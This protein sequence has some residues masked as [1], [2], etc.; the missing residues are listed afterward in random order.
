M[1]NIVDSSFLRGVES[2]LNSLFGIDGDKKDDVKD[3]NKEAS[4]INAIE[5]SSTTKLVM[6]SEPEPE[7]PVKNIEETDQST[8][9]SEIEKRFNAIFGDESKDSKA[10]VKTNEQPAVEEIITSAAREETQNINQFTDASPTVEEIIAN[11]AREEDQNIN[12]VK[13]ELP[14]LEEIILQA[15]ADDKKNVQQ[16]EPDQ[17]TIED[18]ISRAT[19]DDSNDIDKA[20][21]E[22]ASSSSVMYSPLKDIKPIILSL[23]WEIDNVMLDQL[24]TEISKLQELYKD[25]Y[26]ILGFSFILR[27]LGRYIRVRG[28]DSNR[29]SVALLLSVYDNLEDVILSKDMKPES[30]RAILLEDI[31]NY[32]EWV[33]Q[34]KF[35]GS[36][37]QPVREAVVFA[38]RE[39]RDSFNKWVRERDGVMRA[40]EAERIIPLKMQNSGPAGKPT[41]YNVP[42]VLA[43]IKQMTRHEEIVDVLEDFK[44]AISAEINAFKSGNK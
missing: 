36:K 22:I 42:D 35:R 34:I 7:L 31:K 26:T 19:P 21:S 23:E 20:A 14:S 17:P 38:V 6:E 29:G 13:E 43:A 24:D 39:D 25:N 40:G 44:T 41:V 9:I 30:K 33:G 12:Q 18:L 10:K 5:N 15:E 16:Q 3:D 32:K 1:K 11:A 4:Q 2:R 28:T 27:F 37:D 8:F